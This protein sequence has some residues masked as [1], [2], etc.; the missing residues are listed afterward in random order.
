MFDKIKLWYDEGLWTK[1]EV[2]NAVT[3]PEKKPL[4]TPEQYEEITGEPYV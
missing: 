4:L 3:H 1:D 2:R